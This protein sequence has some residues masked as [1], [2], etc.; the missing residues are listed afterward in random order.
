MT[1][2]EIQCLSM[3][4]CQARLELMPAL[5]QAYSLK[6]WVTVVVLLTPLGSPG[7]APLAT[8]EQMAIGRS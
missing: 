3:L 4:G 2:T 1:G 6:A 7:E 8:Q 5:S